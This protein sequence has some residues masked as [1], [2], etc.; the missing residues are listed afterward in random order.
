MAS[1]CGDGE[2]EAEKAEDA[3]RRAA[4]TVAN[5]AESATRLTA[6]LA[7]AA[8]VP[9]PGD[10]DG[11]GTAIVNLDVSKGEACYEV[12]AQKIDR[13]TG[14]HIHE[15]ETGKSGPVVIP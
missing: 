14:M 11:T 12:S 13:P 9:G 6:V 3:A 15:G 1:G 2:D 7:G 5:K 4:T 10:P 8:E